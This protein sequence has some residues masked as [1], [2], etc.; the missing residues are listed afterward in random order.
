MKGVLR[1]L[2]RAALLHDSGDVTD[3]QLLESFLRHEDGAFE[4]LLRRHGAM[5]LGVCRRVLGN[6]HDAEDAFQATF[7]VLVRKAASVRQRS[8]LGNWLYGVAYRTALA[9]RIAAL[10]RR[11]KEATMRNMSRTQAAADDGWRDLQP[12]L[13]QE[14]NRLPDKYRVP[15]VLCDLEGKTRKEAA[16]QLGWPE[17]TVSGRLARARTLL[18]RR[19]TR[20]GLSLSAS[21]L[22]LAL[23]QNT[24]SAGV[25]TGLAIS[26][27]KAVTALQAGQAAVSVQVV[28]LTQ[29]VL[30]AMLLTKLKTIAGIL[31]L[32]TIAGLVTFQGLANQQEGD[33]RNRRAPRSRS[34]HVVAQEKTPVE[35][36]RIFA[37]EGLE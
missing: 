35:V 16:R 18:A 15:I 13:D 23:A 32:M 21:G 14:L 31:A 1:E 26:T 3:A 37:P 4:A 9:A 22:A 19:L 36:R 10:R 30:K 28:A 17:G 5:V 24:A 25:P 11:A 27:I 34:A 29:G 7:L 8:L 6:R 2:R 12:L 20:H 33:P